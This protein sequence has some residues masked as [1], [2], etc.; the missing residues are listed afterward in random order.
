[1]F[2]A[3]PSFQDELASHF[4]YQNIATCVPTPRKLIGQL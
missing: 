2:K 4:H 3:P 1:L